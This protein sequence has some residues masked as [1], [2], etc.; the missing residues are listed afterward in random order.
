MSLDH[1]TVRRIAK[2]ARI[3]LDEDEV[4]RLA[5]ELNAILGYVEQLAEV[6]VEGV[7]PLSGG[8]QM[9]LRMRE[10]AVTDG[11]YPDRVLANAPERIGDF[12]AV[13]K[14]VE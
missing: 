6:D 1:A 8:A 10:D 12:F 11:Q 14:V 9:A 4:P 13:P 3:R 5:G 7:A 2:L